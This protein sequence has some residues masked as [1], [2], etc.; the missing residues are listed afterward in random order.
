MLKL[1]ATQPHILT[2]SMPSTILLTIFSINMFNLGSTGLFAQAQRE[3]WLCTIAMNDV[4]FLAF[5]QSSISAIRIKDLSGCSVVMIT[6]QH[7]AIL[8]HIVSWPSMINSQ[9]Q[10]V[11]DQNAQALMNWVASLYTQQQIYFSIADI[12]IV[13]AVYAGNVALSDQKRIIENNILQ[14]GLS[15][16]FSLFYD[17]PTNCANL[18]QETTL[19]DIKDHVEQRSAVYMENKL[20]S[21]ELIIQQQA[22]ASSSEWILDLTHQ[23][24]RRLVDG[25]WEWVP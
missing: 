17:V 19:I 12:F 3:K 18:G 7:E 8:A 21:E 23:R 15:H 2:A 9:N 24:Y 6:S 10:H 16:L 20:V 22:Q 1:R 25:N 5:H 14:M 4:Q 11:S 13:C